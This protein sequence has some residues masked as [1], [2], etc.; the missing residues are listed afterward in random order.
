MIYSDPRQALVF[1]LNIS[2]ASPAGEVNCNPDPGPSTTVKDHLSVS[3]N[4]LHILASETCT[5]PNPIHISPYSFALHMCPPLDDAL[6]SPK[7]A[8][9]SIDIDGREEPARNTPLRALDGHGLEFGLVIMVHP[10]FGDAV[11]EVGTST[12]IEVGEDLF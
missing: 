3:G 12:S 2:S 9:Y 1:A 7:I 5:I 8:V 6:L 11:L 10:A 4:H